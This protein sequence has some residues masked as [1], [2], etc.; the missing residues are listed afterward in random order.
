M[1]SSGVQNHHAGEKIPMSQAVAIGMIRR[2]VPPHADNEA[3]VEYLQKTTRT[4]KV[5]L[6]GSLLGLIR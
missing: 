3:A 5:K 1:N 2:L 6:S 4:R